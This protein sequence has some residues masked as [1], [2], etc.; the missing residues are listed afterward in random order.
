VHVI[1][2]VDWNPQG[3]SSHFTAPAPERNPTG[4]SWHLPSSLENVPAGQD[5]QLVAGFGGFSNTWEP[6]PHVSHSHAP[7]L[8]ENVFIGHNWQDVPFAEKNPGEQIVHA[9]CPLKFGLFGRYPQP[10]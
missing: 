1:L 3:H 6:G 7:E 9:V 8:E 4:Q 5:S 2:S 10:Q